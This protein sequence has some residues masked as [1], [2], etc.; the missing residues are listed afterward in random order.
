MFLTESGEA[1]SM[2]RILI[3]DDHPL[4][5]RGLRSILESC[6]W[7]VC[8][9]A[10]TGREAIEKATELKPDVAILDIAARIER[11]RC[12]TKNS[13]DIVRNRDSGALGALLRSARK[14]NRPR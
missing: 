9:E 13:G 3:A 10:A 11:D 2:L 1:V 12:W 4:M 14:R 5:R 8:V 7:T 6:G